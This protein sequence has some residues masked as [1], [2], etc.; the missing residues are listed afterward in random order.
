M[1]KTL[2]A[3]IEV[4]NQNYYDK[5]D[6]ELLTK[7]RNGEIDI[8]KCIREL[9]SQYNSS[10]SDIIGPNDDEIFAQSFHTLVHSSSLP[11]ILAK[12]QKYADVIRD[13][14]EKMYDEIENLCLGQQ[15]EMEDHINQLDVS[16]TA[17]NINALLGEQL[18][19]Q[20]TVRKQWESELEGRKGHQK[21]EYRNWI[22]GQV[23][24]NFLRQDVIHTP[25]GSR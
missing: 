6:D 8:E 20:S 19:R 10:T 17:E 9:E 14:T 22:N 5:Q 2:S 12:E 4:E 25:M 24:Q 3:F 21:Q 16:T 18:A 13:F 1:L 23:M 15:L 11:N 7:A